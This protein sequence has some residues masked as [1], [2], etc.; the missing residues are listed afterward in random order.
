M[1]RNRRTNVVLALVLALTSLWALASA[2]RAETYVGR[3]IAE[4]LF[5]KLKFSGRV[6]VWP[7]DA[8]QAR[9]ARLSSSDA[10]MLTD[11]IRVAIQHL[12]A[13]KGV[14]FV[15]REAISKIFQEQQFAH[16]A[17]DSDF[18]KLARQAHADALVL[19]SLQRKDA[20]EIVVSARLV[21]SAGAAIGQ[22]LAT[23]KVYEVEV[24]QAAIPKPT[25][26][27]PAPTAKSAT[28]AP[29]PADARKPVL[30]TPLPTVLPDT[31]TPTPRA[32][33]SPPYQT[34]TYAP[35]YPTTPALAYAYQPAPYYIRPR[36]AF[37]YWRR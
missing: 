37:G 31:V 16:G 18:E 32:S 10:A 5:E 33:A 19:I 4:D 2:A 28:G 20:A 30:G 26:N 35:A 22:I 15:E 12:G 27:A 34:Y 1:K 8:A 25:G 29:P 23:S 21:R 13:A 36:V 9:A 17:K 7:L 11:N 3:L 24:A 6:A 14:T